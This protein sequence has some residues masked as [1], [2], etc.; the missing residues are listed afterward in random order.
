MIWLKHVRLVFWIE[1]MIVIVIKVKSKCNLKKIYCDYC[2]TNLQLLYSIT[3]IQHLLIKHWK[4]TLSI[5]FPF[6]VLQLHVFQPVATRSPGWYLSWYV[7]ISGFFFQKLVCIIIFV[8][9]IENFLTM[10]SNYELQWCGKHRI[11]DDDLQRWTLIGKYRFFLYRMRTAEL[12]SRR[13][14]IL[15]I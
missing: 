10:N 8:Y 14:V 12:V 13:N 4:K 6:S 2:K 11:F 1:L 3:E 7:L 5:S 9:K 15:P